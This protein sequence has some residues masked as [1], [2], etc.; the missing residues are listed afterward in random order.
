VPVLAD[1]DRPSLRKSHVAEH[2]LNAAEWMFSVAFDYGEGHY[3]E[4]ELAASTAGCS[5]AR[6]AGGR[7]GWETAASHVG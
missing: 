3:R 2:D 4:Q 5:A 7:P 1:S 6:A